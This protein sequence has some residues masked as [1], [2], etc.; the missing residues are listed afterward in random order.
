MGASERKRATYRDVLDA[1]EGMIAELIDGTLYLQPRPA[2]PHTD[3]ASRLGVLLGGPFDLG[4]NGPG[5]WRIL[6]EPEI[7]F[8]S[9]VLVPDLAGWLVSETP[10]FDYAL[11]HY[12]ERPNWVC[13]VLSP[14]TARRD[15]MMKLEVYHRVGV[16]WAWLVDPAGQTVE[17]FRWSEAGWVRLPSPARPSEARLEPFD[18]VALDLELLFPGGND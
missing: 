17:G 10:A 8:G 9:E 13:E 15:R 16:R 14:S 11:A 12:E 7:H 3:A 2:K 18:P 1:P 5:G 4:Q 6:F